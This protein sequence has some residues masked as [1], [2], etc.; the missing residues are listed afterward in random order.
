MFGFDIGSGVPV[1]GQGIQQGLIRS[2]E[3]HSQKHQLG[4]NDAV[5]AGNIDGNELPLLVLFP[6]D[7]NEVHP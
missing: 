7:L 2:E 4:G 3:A 6:F 5:G 1:H